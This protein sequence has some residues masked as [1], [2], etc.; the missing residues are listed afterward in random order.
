MLIIDVKFLITG[1]WEI[2]KSPEYPNNV[3]ISISWYP[4]YYFL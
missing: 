2:N 1:T 3:K 4:E